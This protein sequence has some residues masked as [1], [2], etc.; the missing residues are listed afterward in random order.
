MKYI[1]PLIIILVFSCTSNDQEV[2]KNFTP[3]FYNS[4]YVTWWDVED[5]EEERQNMD[6]YL[7]GQEYVDK[8]KHKVRLEG[9]QPPTIV[10]AY[11][12]AWYFSDKRKHEHYI[13][14]SYKR[15]IM[16]SI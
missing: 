12:S 6:I 1:L 14:P 3:I 11:G 10:F 7:R 2:A 15:A 4:N 5:G 8:D 9:K 16:W 13:S